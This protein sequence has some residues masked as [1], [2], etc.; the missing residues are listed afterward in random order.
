[1]EKGFADRRQRSKAGP[2]SAA[3]GEGRSDRVKRVL[4]FS[5]SVLVVVLSIFQPK[6]A[7]TPIP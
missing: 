5:F 1:M 6:A 3:N 7:D 4:P 2:S